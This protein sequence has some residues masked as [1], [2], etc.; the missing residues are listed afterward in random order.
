MFTEVLKLDM[1]VPDT[2]SYIG[3]PLVIC[4]LSVL[5]YCD[6]S[7]VDFVEIINSTLLCDKVVETLHNRSFEYTSIPH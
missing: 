6:M 5:C 3:T 1:K 2:K 4:P 7:E